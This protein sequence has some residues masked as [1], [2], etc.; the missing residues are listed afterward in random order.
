MRHLLLENNKIK[1]IPCEISNLC[2]LNAINLTDNPIEY[3]PLDVVQKG[4]KSILEYMRN[5]YLNKK[6][7]E[8]QNFSE[9]SAYKSSGNVNDYDFN[10]D[11]WASDDEG[12]LNQKQASLKFKYKLND[13]LAYSKK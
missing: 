2:N 9:D 10:D 13:H 4:C 3:P 8:D 5:D 1:R 12:N 7:I 11:V 6:K